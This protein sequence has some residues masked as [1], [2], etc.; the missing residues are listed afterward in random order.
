MQQPWIF[1]FLLAGTDCEELTRH[2]LSDELS[3]LIPGLLD[4]NMLPVNRA[5]QIDIEMQPLTHYDW[6]AYEPYL[7]DHILSPAARRFCLSADGE[8]EITPLRAR[9]RR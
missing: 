7:I 5:L 1:R 8:P 4:L 6:E 9:T 2:E 3:A